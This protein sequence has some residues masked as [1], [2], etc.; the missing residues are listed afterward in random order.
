M[1]I[2]GH[3]FTVQTFT[4]NNACC[5]Y[6]TPLPRPYSTIAISLTANGPIQPTFPIF[7]I[8]KL[9]EL[10]LYFARFQIKLLTLYY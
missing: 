1:C 2:T 8:E 5:S 9:F 10:F 4:V 7:E 3:V 6:T